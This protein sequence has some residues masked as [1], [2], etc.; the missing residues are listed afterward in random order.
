MVLK[1]R[2][3]SLER[4]WPRR[5]SLLQLV[6]ETQSVARLTGLTYDTAFER[7]L[8]GVTDDEIEQMIAEAEAAFGVHQVR[9][10]PLE[11]TWPAEPAA[12]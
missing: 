6:R 8:P 12:L 7:L 2:I 1:R 4:T 3:A 11:S 9:G 10:I 5:R